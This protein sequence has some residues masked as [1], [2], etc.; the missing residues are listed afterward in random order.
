MVDFSEILKPSL[1]AVWILDRPAESFPISPRWI[2]SILISVVSL[3]FTISLVVNLILRRRNAKYRDKKKDGSDITEITP[4]GDTEN[5]PDII[6]AK[7][8]ITDFT[9]DLFNNY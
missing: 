9:N 4:P 2:V 5:S 1:L 7:G 6:P 8:N 3:L